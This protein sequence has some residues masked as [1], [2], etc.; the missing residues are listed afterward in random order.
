VTEPREIGVDEFRETFAE[1]RDELSAVVVGQDRVV[2]HLLAAI[3]AGGHVLLK[4]LPG[5]GRTLLVKTLAEVLGL[6]YRR[7]QFTPDLL[8]TDIIGAEVLESSQSTGERRFRFF[9]GPVFANLLLA[10]EINR[11]PTRTQN[12]LLEVMQERQVSVSGQTYFLPKPFFLVATQNTLDTEGVFNLGEAQVDRFLMM[13]EQG[14]PGQ[15]DEKRMVGLTT[16]A[17]KV[18]PRKIT[19]PE[20]ILGMQRIA[21]EVPVVP[22]VRDFALAVVR[23]SRPGEESGAEEIKG[24]IRLGASPRAA[25]G[26]LLSAKVLALARG[27]RHVT[28][29]DIIDVVRPVMAHRVLVD[30]RARAEGITQESILDQLI[31]GARRMSVPE[32]SR[33]TREVLRSGKEELS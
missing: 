33:W 28:R 5:L 8:P 30:F 7:I 23:A 12:A 15:G 26:L 16:G 22:A 14:Y 29:Q 24:I 2:E 17:R 13:I 18:Q 4:G 10:D 6:E 31:E 19:D 9:K 21:R 27:R 1:I 11:S 32:V 20:T 25:Q 3:F